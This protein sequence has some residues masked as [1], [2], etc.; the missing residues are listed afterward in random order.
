MSRNLGAYKSCQVFLNF[1]FDKAFV[2][3]ANAMSF[4]VVAS[5][6]LPVCAYDLTT[7]DKPRLEMLVEAI[8][9][10]NYS[11]HDLSRSHGEGALNLARMNMPL[12]MGMALFHAIH[13]QRRDHRCIFFVS[14]KD[15]YRDFVS[16]LSGL[17]PKTHNGDEIR[18][19]SEMYDW[20]RR[21]VPVQIFNNKPTLEVI[22]KFGEF[23]RR[24]ARARG[25]GEGGCPSH[26][27]NREVMYQVCSEVGWWDW[28]E[29]R[30]GKEE[31]PTVPLLFKD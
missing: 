22:D 23:K 27:E 31:F 26:D 7:P 15:D 2:E 6:L 9:S 24:I 3:L 8:E 20:L 21:V 5:G 19:L 12:E 29:T 10:C 30:L 16:D 18:L 28:R 1:P 17:D 25:S 11:A 13:T 4:A 14:T